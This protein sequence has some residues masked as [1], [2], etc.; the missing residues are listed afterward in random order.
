[1]ASSSATSQNNSNSLEASDNQIIDIRK[2]KRM[3]SN[4]ES[5]RRSRQR[6]QKQL[7]DLTAEVSRLRDQN[8]QILSTV[9]V[10]TQLYMNMEAE[11]SVLK[12]QLSELTNRLNS[13]NEIIRCLSSPAVKNTAITTS[14]ESDEKESCGNGS[15]D[16]DDFDDYFSVNSFGSAWGIEIPAA[17]HPIMPAPG[18]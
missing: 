13:L 2:R 17:A 16:L 1:M 4:R 14:F 5:A 12:A 15:F 9:N 10:T 3:Q 11:N 18:V 6:K 8:G 7:D